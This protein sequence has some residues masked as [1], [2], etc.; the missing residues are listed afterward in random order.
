MKQR[1]LRFLSYPE[2][3][4]GRMTSLE[5]FSRLPVLETTDLI[6]RP[7]RRDDAED[8]F[9]WSSD[10][11]VARYVLWEPHQDLRD[12][13]AYLRYMRGLYRSGQPSSWGM[14]LRETGAVIGTVGFMWL[15]EENRSAE[16]GYSLARPCWNRGLATQALSAVVCSAFSSLNL[17]R[18]EAQRD[19]RNPASGRVLEKCGFSQE[20]ILRSR[21]RNKGEFI[22]V[23]LYA[24]LRR[25]LEETP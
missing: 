10:P 21:I 24:I 13:R 20:G 2:R 25:D 7:L 9:S 18:I 5:Y 8:L 17:N 14:V 23:V 12:T 16:V 1:F 19:L 22:D 4:D 11:E 6:L 3:P 15:S